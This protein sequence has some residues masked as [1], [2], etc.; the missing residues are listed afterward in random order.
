MEL[1]AMQ[2]YIY[3]YC[4]AYERTYIYLYLGRFLTL[5]EVFKSLH[6]TGIHLTY[7]L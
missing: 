2:I 5:A 4:S 1:D 3:F 7:S 6:L